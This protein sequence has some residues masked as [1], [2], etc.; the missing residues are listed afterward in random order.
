MGRMADRTRRAL[1]GVA[2]SVA[3]LAVAL[4]LPSLLGSG[5]QDTARPRVV[6]TPPSTRPT[7]TPAAGTAAPAT[8]RTPTGAGTPAIRPPFAV[9]VVHTTV[10]D[11]SRPTPARGP[12]RASPYRTLPLTVRYPV[13]GAAGAD[14][15][16]DAPSLAGHFPLVVFA[17]GFALADATYPR[18]LHDLAAEGFVVADPELPLSSSARPGPAIGGDEV[19]QARDLAFVADVMLDRGT[20]PA[21][22]AALA[23]AP[24]IAAAGHSDGGVTAAGL[25][26]NACCA[27]PRVGAAVILSG[28]L[29]HFPGGW[30][31]SVSPPLLA[32]HGDADEVN[33][34]SSSVGVYQ[35]ARPPKM[36]VAVR[37][38]SHIGA[39]EDDQRRPA[40]TR[41]VADFLR[42]YLERDAAAA[43]R[44]TDDAGTPGVLDLL[45]AER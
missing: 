20:R 8:T 21:P 12:T 7:T 14:E 16:A 9:G 41:L 38:G 29:A 6:P 27:D 35:A 26:G 30:F 18:F 31:T 23:L 15:S 25:A 42:A 40:V 17:H 2:A 19:E 11:P 13:A 10:V 33:P 37:G 34:L 43:A 28:A 32:V 45:A 24:P 36:L 39:F 44:L 22:L 4:G 5:R 3:V 1:V